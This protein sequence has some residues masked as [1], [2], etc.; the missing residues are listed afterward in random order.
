MT[1][2]SEIDILGALPDDIELNAE[3]ED[4]LSICGDLLDA[5]APP[6]SAVTDDADSAQDD[7]SGV[8]FIGDDTLESKSRITVSN[9]CET[10]E[11]LETRVGVVIPA[12]EQL[13][14]PGIASV[15]GDE[16]F[17]YKDFDDLHRQSPSVSFILAKHSTPIDFDLESYSWLRRGDF[18]STSMN[19]LA[20]ELGFNLNRL[21]SGEAET[22]VTTL[23]EIA[24]RSSHLIA[25]ICAGLALKGSTKRITDALAAMI[26]S[27]AADDM[28]V[29][30]EVLQASASLR[31]GPFSFSST[32]R[33]RDVNLRLRIS[34]FEHL[35]SLLS[36]P[37]P[38]DAWVEVPKSEYHLD[39]WFHENA[40]PV[41]VKVSIRPY[42]CGSLHLFG[43]KEQRKSMQVSWVSSQEFKALMP[44]A[45]LNV[46][47]MLAATG[48]VSAGQAFGFDGIVENPFWRSS[49]S[50]GIVAESIVNALCSDYTSVSLDMLTVRANWICSVSRTICLNEA[51]PLTD[52]GVTIKGVGT[53]Y[54][55][56]SLPKQKLSKLRSHLLGNSKLRMPVIN[57][58]DYE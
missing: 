21:D 7:D 18:F 11:F 19:D 9:C 28:P 6:V 24:S 55:D 39:T 15:A 35:V 53:T 14:G 31:H 22:C 23:S 12:S 42:R 8:Q 36:K 41:M 27:K 38:D 48:K 25:P 33:I 50:A 17:A 29:N 52:L 20:N 37:V 51:I 34:R 45:S 26:A 40:P 10:S 43:G 1:V 16:C 30:S 58:A 54:V 56:V 5:P 44:Y 2:V 13:N 47:R 46:N 57:D 49:L 3:P 32:S 4:L